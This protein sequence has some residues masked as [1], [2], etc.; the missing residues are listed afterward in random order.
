MHTG[1][2]RW[3]LSEPNDDMLAFVQS[4]VTA[5]AGMATSVHGKWRLVALTGSGSKKMLTAGA[6][7]D[8]ML[9][10]RQCAALSLFDCPAIVA[11]RRDGYDVWVGASYAAAFMAKL[12][13]I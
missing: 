13:T 10:G 8:S 1:P 4:A 9:T 6:D 3:L 7:L 5:G 11:T 12:Q 2:G